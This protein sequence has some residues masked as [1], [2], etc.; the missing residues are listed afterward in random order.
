M[1][2]EAAKGRNIKVG[3]NTVMNIRKLR[4]ED[5]KRLFIIVLIPFSESK[6]IVKNWAIP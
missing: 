2:L 1:P 5:A 4:I 3:I 6:L